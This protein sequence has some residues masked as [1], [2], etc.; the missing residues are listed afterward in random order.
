MSPF[1]ESLLAR[2]LQPAESIRPR[3]VSRF[4]PVRGFGEGAEAGEGLP[5][6]SPLAPPPE[7]SALPP[8]GP[9]AGDEPAASTI[10]LTPTPRL[11]AQRRSAVAPAPTPAEAP[12]TVG[13]LPPAEPLVRPPMPLPTA[14]EPLPDRPSPAQHPSAVAS[15]VPRSTAQPQAVEA[16]PSPKPVAEVEPSVLRDVG[17][18]PAR[19]PHESGT[20]E[21]RP[22]PGMRVRPAAPVPPPVALAPQAEHPAPPQPP[23]STTLQP[24]VS[25]TE[26]TPPQAPTPRSSRLAR[27]PIEPRTVAEPSTADLGPQPLEARR[28]AAL[29]P[30]NPPMP[31]PVVVPDVRPRQTAPGE[32]AFAPPA[33]AEATPT[34][35]ISIGRIE[36]RAVTPAPPPRRKP[37]RPAPALSLDE[38]LKQQKRR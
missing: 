37:S 10:R 30:A 32:P 31:L 6:A 23:K 3:R 38:Y 15:V 33:P 35:R 24:T 17:G 2:S 12:R 34:I 13:L 4:E 36:V 19:A 28:D 22:A 16:A 26:E 7:P 18:P 11:E 1:L 8:P 27:L 21:P 9:S 20:D 25:M 29:P 5:A 14:A